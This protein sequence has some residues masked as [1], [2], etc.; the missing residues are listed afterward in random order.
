[1][2]AIFLDMSILESNQSLCVER[3]VRF[4]SDQHNGDAA[5]PVELLKH[6]HDFFGSFAVE[7]SC[8]LVGKDDGRVAGNGARQGHALLLST[9]QLIWK[10]MLLFA[11]KPTLQGPVVHAL[12]AHWVR[13]PHKPLEVRRS[14]EHSCGESN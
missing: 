13:P 3:D 7:S 11:P 14:R 2:D 6:S 1:M 9:R 5:F 8:R 10:T 4:V 12:D